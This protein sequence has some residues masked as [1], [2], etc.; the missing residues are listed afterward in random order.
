MNPASCNVAGRTHR[1][2]TTGSLDRETSLPISGAAPSTR[3]RV[4]RWSS[5][6]GSQRVESGVHGSPEP[7]RKPRRAGEGFV[8]HAP[9]LRDG[10]AA[11][12]QDQLV[13]GREVVVGAAQKNAGLGGILE[14][15]QQ[16]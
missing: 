13:L 15:G 5:E 7:V 1:L 16:R 6:R 10:F 11:G 12:L 8:R 9:L 2:L 14:Y 3:V 4:R